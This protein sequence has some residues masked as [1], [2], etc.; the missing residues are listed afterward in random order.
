M[1][2]EDLQGGPEFVK[3]VTLTVGCADDAMFLGSAAEAIANG[4]LVSN[5]FYFDA[6]DILGGPKLPPSRAIHC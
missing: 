3:E 1:A 4:P 5:D 6:N 2:F